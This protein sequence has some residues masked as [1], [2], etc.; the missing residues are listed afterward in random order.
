[1]KGPGDPGHKQPFHS[2]LGRVLLAGR[3]HKLPDTAILSA[4]PT[5]LYFPSSQMSNLLSYWV[6]MSSG[7]CEDTLAQEGSVTQ[8]GSSVRPSRAGACLDLHFTSHFANLSPHSLSLHALRWSRLEAFP[9]Q[10]IPSPARSRHCGQ[11]ASSDPVLMLKLG[12]GRSCLR[13]PEAPR[14]GG[15]GACGPTSEFL[16]LMARGWICWE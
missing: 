13:A 5:L 16:G 7:L 8:L 2:V 15:G 12:L 14:V 4:L 1:M 9:G 10:R 6:C 3:G 11:Q